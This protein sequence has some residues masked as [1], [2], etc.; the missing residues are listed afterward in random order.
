VNRHAEWIAWAAAIL[1]WL[2]AILAI[3]ASVSV[4]TM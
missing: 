4:K 3:I 2:A 1:L